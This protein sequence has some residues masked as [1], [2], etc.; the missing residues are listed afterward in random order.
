ML[1]KRLNCPCA[2]VKDARDCLRKYTVIMKLLKK[3]L[4]NGGD[5]EAVG[6]DAAIATLD[7]AVAKGTKFGESWRTC[8]RSWCDRV[9]HYTRV[10]HGE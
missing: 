2:I 1:L 6:T 3:G 7:D 4:N 5:D 9:G 10:P 8:E